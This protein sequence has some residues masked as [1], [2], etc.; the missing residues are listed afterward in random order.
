M[1]TPELLDMPPNVK[2]AIKGLLQKTFSQ[3]NIR[4]RGRSSSEGN[5]K[6][7]GIELDPE[8]LRLSELY[9]SQFSKGTDVTKSS[10][11]RKALE[12]FLNSV[13]LVAEETKSP[14]PK[15]V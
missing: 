13:N 4:G 10:V 15:S 14:I 12:Y 8:L 5:I 7:I 11:V 9:A 3:P 2:A 1:E 6:R